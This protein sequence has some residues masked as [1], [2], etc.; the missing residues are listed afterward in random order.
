MA[1]SGLARSVAAL[2]RLSTA[3]TKEASPVNFKEKVVDAQLAGLGAL[4]SLGGKGKVV[5]VPSR[6]LV[7]LAKVVD[8]R[9]DD[10]ELGSGDNIDEGHVDD[11]ATG[12]GVEEKNG[13]GG[14]AL[15]GGVEEE[16]GAGGNGAMGDGEEEKNGAGGNG[17]M[18]DGE[19]EKNGAGG[20]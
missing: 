18:G 15:G 16:S 6:K 20:K 12:G 17:A 4:Y 8:G 10:G 13:P 14:V 1:Q 5:K 9:V 3:I 19:E 11:D 7:K 2:G